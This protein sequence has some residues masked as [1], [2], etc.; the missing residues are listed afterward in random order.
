M[1]KYIS[2]STSIFSSL[3]I[4]LLGKI[5]FHEHE[6]R[7]KLLHRRA[8]KQF[9]LSLFDT[10]GRVIDRV[11][12]IFCSNEY[13][14][15]LNK[16]FLNHDYFTDTLSFILSGKKDPVIGE[17]Y[18]SVDMINSNSAMY[19]VKY[20]DELLRV[21]IHSCLHLCG[22]VDKPAKKYREM[23]SRQESWLKRWCVSRETAT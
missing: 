20:Q 21:I 19:K 10:E 13:L 9:L 17:L 1:G 14:L 16:G 11:D 4:I 23:I 12:I 2:L 18:I 5:H 3:E 6:T 8:L 22:Y 15:T 7:S